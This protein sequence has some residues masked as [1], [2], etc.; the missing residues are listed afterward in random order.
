L[1]WIVSSGSV[2]EIARTGAAM[3]RQVRRLVDDNQIQPRDIRNFD[4]I[5]IHSS[6]M[7]LTMETLELDGVRDP[8]VRKIANPKE[9]FTGVIMVNGDGSELQ[10][11]SMIRGT[12]LKK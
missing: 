11:N 6:P 5:R 1:F 4:E 12:M 8:L 10:V 2:Q 9:A 3:V 7:D